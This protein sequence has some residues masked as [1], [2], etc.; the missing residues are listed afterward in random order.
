MKSIIIIA[1]DGRTFVAPIVNGI[2]LKMLNELVD[3]YIEVVPAK[4]KGTVLVVNEEGKLRGL[5]FNARATNISQLYG[6]HIVGVAVLCRKDGE[7]LVP[8]DTEAD[9]YKLLDEWFQMKPR[10]CEA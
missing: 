4:P 9:A 3:G 6:S 2:T 8:F 10:R 1:P 7:D 5:H